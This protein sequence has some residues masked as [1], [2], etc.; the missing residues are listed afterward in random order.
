MRFEPIEDLRDRR[1][2][3]GPGVVHTRAVDGYGFVRRRA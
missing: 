1:V 2:G 3:G